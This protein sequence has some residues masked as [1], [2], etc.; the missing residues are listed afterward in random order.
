MHAGRATTV[1]A[2]LREP[3]RFID[4]HRTSVSKLFRGIKVNVKV[5]CIGYS[6]TVGLGLFGAYLPIYPCPYLPSS[7]PPIPYQMV[8]RPH[9]SA[10]TLD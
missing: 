2:A 3:L 9:A 5:I 7:Y 4:T 8:P 10:V 1:H 6:D